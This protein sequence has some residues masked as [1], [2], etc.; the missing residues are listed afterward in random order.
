M[1]TGTE[2]KRR[3]QR[4]EAGRGPKRDVCPVRIIARDEADQARQLAALE[5]SGA[6]TP[7]TVVVCRLIVSRNEAGAPC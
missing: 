2:I 5:A 1:G 6:I 7:D 4:L 3:L